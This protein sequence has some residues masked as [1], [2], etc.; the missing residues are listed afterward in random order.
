MQSHQESQLSPERAVFSQV[1]EAGLGF[2][3]ELARGQVARIVDLHGNQAVDTLFF[4]ARDHDERY[5]ATETIRRQG[6]IYLTTGSALRSSEGRVLLTIVGTHAADDTLGGALG[7]SNR[8]VPLTSIQH[9]DGTA[10]LG[11]GPPC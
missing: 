1:I 8:C 9:N 7:R 10:S 3:H 4:N 5:S 11:A 2:T 6:N